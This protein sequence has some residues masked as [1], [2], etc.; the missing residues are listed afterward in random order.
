M[1]FFVFFACGIAGG[2]LGGMGMGG[3]TLF[4]PLLS[5]VCGVAQTTAQSVNLLCFLPMSCVALEVHA[6]NGLIGKEGLFF[7]IASALVFSAL[8]SLVASQLPQQTLAKSFGVFLIVFSLFEFKSA[9]FA[10]KQ[11]RR[12]IGRDR[13]AKGAEKRGVF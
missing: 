1:S 5:A 2:V 3:G 9:L 12:G 11:F 7:P 13:S 10:G 8:A 6:R 4:I